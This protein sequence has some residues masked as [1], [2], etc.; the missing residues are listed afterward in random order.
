VAAQGR[1]ADPVGRVHRSP[2]RADRHA[3]LAIRDSRHEDHARAIL[4]DTQAV[5]TSEL[6]L[7]GVADRDGD[8]PAVDSDR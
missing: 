6:S 1:P 5:I 4:A 8:A 2:C 7:A 3:V